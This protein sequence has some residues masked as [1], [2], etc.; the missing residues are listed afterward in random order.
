MAALE[1]TVL[2]HHAGETL[3]RLYLAHAGDAPC[4]W[5][6]IARFPDSRRFKDALSRLLSSRSTDVWVLLG[7]TASLAAVVVALVR[8]TSRQDATAVAIVLLLSVLAV[9]LSWALV[10]TVFAF[11]YARLYYFDEPDC[12]GIDFKQNEPP[13]YSDFA[14]LAFT[15]GMS[16][17]VSETEPTSTRTRRVALMDAL[18]VSVR[19]RDPGGRRQPR[20][21][22]GAVNRRRPGHS[23]VHRDAGSQ[24]LKPARPC[25]GLGSRSTSGTWSGSRTR[26]WPRSGR[27]RHGAAG[28]QVSP[29]RPAPRPPGGRPHLAEVYA[30]MRAPSAAVHPPDCPGLAAGG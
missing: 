8:S 7:A 11:K 13:T 19:H 25:L 6:E 29:R 17:A 4:P 26:P 3:M 24:Y 18:L 10:N 23:A 14:Y 5:M 28:W 2:L 22:P 21:Q 30:R 15:V 12:A 1:S 20:H 9:V 27:R 16:F